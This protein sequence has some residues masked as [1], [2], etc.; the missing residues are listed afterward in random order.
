MLTLNLNQM[1][2]LPTKVR[3]QGRTTVTLATTPTAKKKNRPCR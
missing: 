2:L 3:M 1:L